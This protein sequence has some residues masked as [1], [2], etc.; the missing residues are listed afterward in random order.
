MNRH[1]SFERLLTIA[2]LATALFATAAP[3][4]Q[5]RLRSMLQTRSSTDRIIVKLRSGYRSEALRNQPVR[6]MAADRASALS[7]T[8]GIALRAVRPMSDDAQVVAL[9][10]AMRNESVQAVVA[11][12]R[13]DPTVEYAY[14]DAR[15]HLAAIPNDPLFAQ[16]TYLEAP[17]VAPLAASINAP[18]AWDIT[19]G[20]SAARIAIV[21]GGV[22]F[23]HPD[24]A[25]RLVGGYDFV[26]ADCTIGDS[27]C[28][29][30]N[31]FTTANDGDGRD[32]DA[33][34]PG[35]WVG[36]GAS[37]NPFLSGCSVETSSW[38]GTHIAG[39]IGAVGNNGLG[40]TGLNWNATMVPIRVAGRCG[41]YRS[42][43]VDGLR[44]SAGLSVPNVPTNPNPAKIINISLGSAG[45]C[46]TSAYNQTV[47]DVLATGAIIVAAAGNEDATPILP[48]SCPGVISVGAVRGD[49]TRA[50]YSNSGSGLTIMAPGGDYTS[51]TNDR[52]L[53]TDNAGTTTPVPYTMAGFY[54][55]GAGTSFSTPVVSGVVS[56]MLSANPNLTSTQVIDVLRTTARAFTSVAGYATCVPGGGNN[57]NNTTP[58]N[59]TTA[60]CGAGYVDANAAVT[61]AFA[62]AGG[63][64]PNAPVA[65]PVVAASPAAGTSSS[66]GGGGSVDPTALLILGFIGV[67]T[68]GLRIADAESR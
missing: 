13:L 11:R 63:V 45:T 57:A 64:S 47:I 6:A 24:L 19:K 21:D 30:A 10:Q 67:A 38:H 54:A 20:T 42:D 7:R 16:Q 9:P 27:G 65:A 39:I 23:D 4:Q 61:R 33:S 58:C 50:V 49:G 46:A 44:W 51:A 62:L 15:E 29:T 60:A 36:N 14:V 68:R 56:L 40:V 41:G 17:G 22:R 37:S 5:V 18:S 1:R 59:C 35:D 12:L 26:S 52:L 53:S 66:G 48:S 3:A 2:S 43:V 25:G 55:S 34:D 32:P 31:Q 8:A 28:T